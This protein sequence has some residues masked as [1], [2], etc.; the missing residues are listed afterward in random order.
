MAPR[1]AGDPGGLGHLADALT[2]LSS[3]TDCTQPWS[4]PLALKGARCHCHHPCPSVFPRT[5]GTCGTGAARGPAA[6]REG[7][8]VGA[9]HGGEA[10]VSPHLCH[11]QP[12]IANQRS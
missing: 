5:S 8:D 11:F 10:R 9:A 6:R 12:A 1:R 3:T 4:H 2:E 7:W